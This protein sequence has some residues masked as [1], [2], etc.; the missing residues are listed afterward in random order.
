MAQSW[1]DLLF[2]HWSYEPEVLARLLPAP[3]E[4]ELHGGRA[5]VGV[6]PFRMSGVRLRGTPALPWLSAFP[7]L[8][9]RTYVTLDGLPGVWFF[10]LEATNPVAVRVARS[11]FHLPYFDA[12]MACEAEGEAVAYRSSRTHRGAPA[13]ELRGRYAPTGSVGLAEPGSL[14][15]FLTERY[16]LFA[17]DPIALGEG[18][19]EGGKARFFKGEIHHAPW[20]LQPAEAELDAAS[21][22]AAAGLPAPTGEPH[23]RFARELH[24][25]IWWPE[26]LSRR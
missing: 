23:L 19:P 20:P 26:R 22:L 7:E 18:G 9:L 5:W 10:S 2:A 25:R 16:R 8:N 14:E 6:V 12:R 15:A 11:W 1:H 3:L 4:P 21:L 24:V 13:A 17:R